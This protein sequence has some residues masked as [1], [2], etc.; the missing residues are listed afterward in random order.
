M[1]LFQEYDV[2]ANFHVYCTVL[3]DNMF[4]YTLYPKNFTSI[5]IY[6]H[7]FMS[8]SASQVNDNLKM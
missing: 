3:A 5:C 6:S 2:I 4:I 7:P 8:N 1:Y